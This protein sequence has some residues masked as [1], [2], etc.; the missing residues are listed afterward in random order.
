M[1]LAFE[2]TEIDMVLAELRRS[3]EPVSIEPRAF[4][5][6]CLL[7]SNR[8]RLVT[9]DEIVAKIWDSRY[10]S[11]A[12][13]STCVKSVRKAIGDDGDQQRLIKTVRGRGFRFIGAV[14]ESALE[15]AL[16]AGPQTHS[17]HPEPPEEHGKPSIV[18]LPFE[19]YGSDHGQQLLAEAI[20]HELI[21]GLAKLRWLRVIARGT[22]FQF[23]G[24]N[25]D[26]AS[27]GERLAVRYALTGT[28]LHFQDMMSVSVE[29]AHCESGLVIWAERFE[30][31]SDRFLAIRREMLEQIASSLEIYI[32]QR[33]A[34]IAARS[35]TE[36]LD[37]W[38]EY[39][40]GLRHLF[41]FTEA[42]NTAAK[43][44]FERAIEK[45]PE[46]ARAHAGLSF[47]RFQDAF[48][49]YSSDKAAAIEE[50]RRF[51]ERSVELDPLDPFANLNLG[52]SFWLSND[53]ALGLGWLERSISLSP[54]FAQ[55]HYSRAFAEALQGRSGAA[56][57][58]ASAALDLSP[59][60]PLLYAMHGVRALA[61][62]QAGE[63]E[64]ATGEA[65]AAVHAPR[66]HHLIYMIAAATHA[67][68]D[69][70]PAAR[71]YALKARESGA[72]TRTEHFF[73]AFPFVE[74][75]FREE[76]KRGLTL[77]GFD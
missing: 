41:L 39:H 45:D 73:R 37:A 47:G 57:K 7:I 68:A 17:P 62:L 77:A 14:R 40:L 42:N 74:P 51:A 69:D 3:G 58:H 75:G 10:I 36:K 55:G 15:A 31:R 28:V 60:D 27:I 53:P 12:A 23:R 22:A 18:V 54:N 29:L 34:S 65:A 1:K 66:A 46:F 49:G 61:N 20:P 21:Q 70:L 32:T 8:D 33:E 67:L 5:L 43:S 6:L 56:L 38:A 24:P 11:D 59:L 48:V 30:D 64:A 35:S 52:R 2:N 26:L 9:K 72:D 4:D 19:D 25:L 76:F 44:C 50:A 16:P 71:Q 13:I 63:L